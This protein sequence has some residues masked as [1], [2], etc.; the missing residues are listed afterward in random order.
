MMKRI[1]LL[2]VFTILGL[3]FI[4][5][6][7]S[8][9][10][11]GKVLNKYSLNPIP[12]AVISLVNEESSLVNAY[13][14]SNKEGFF[15]IEIPD[16]AQ[17][18]H[19]LLIIESLAYEARSIRL[20]SLNPDMVIF[21]EEKSF[22]LNEVV[23]S[24][25]PSVKQSVDTIAYDPKAYMDSTERTLEDV[26]RKIPGVEIAQNG[27]ISFGNQEIKSIL[28]DGDDLSGNDYRLISQN[29]P[30][31]MVK[32]LEFVSNYVENS[33][34]VGF[35]VP[36]SLILNVELNPEKG[37]KP[38]FN[39][40]LGLGNAQSRIASLN[41]LLFLKNLKLIQIAQH[42]SIGKS[43]ATPISNPWEGLQ[44]IVTAH[45]LL[46]GMNKV[47]SFENPEINLPSDF[48]PFR[49]NS[50]TWNVSRFHLKPS[51][52]FTSFLEIG[53]DQY[54]EQQFMEIRR[55]FSGTQNQLLF[56]EDYRLSNQNRG[57]HLQLKNRLNTGKKSNLTV[58]N[59][60][61]R[62]TENSLSQLEL[63]VD[64]Y[65]I[66]FSKPDSR[67][68]H[69][70]AWLFRLDRKN[71]FIL[72]GGYADL[73]ST[74]TLGIQTDHLRKILNEEADSLQYQN[75]S[76]KMDHWNGN[77]RWMHRLSPGINFVVAARGSSQE[78]M[79]N[80][81]RYEKFVANG[82]L[83]IKYTKPRRPTAFLELH[84]GRLALNLREANS[85][86]KN[87]IRP[88]FFT[89][90][91]IGRKQINGSWNISY[92]FHQVLPQIDQ[93]A[94]DPFLLTYRNYQQGISELRLGNKHKISA[95]FISHPNLSNFNR[96]VKM[97]KIELSKGSFDYQNEFRIDSAF[98]ISNW[99]IRENDFHRVEIWG[100]V[101]RYFAKFKTAIKIRPQLSSSIYN[102]SLDM[103][104]RTIY[105]V[106]YALQLFART[107]TSSP[108]DF[109]LGGRPSLNHFFL[110]Q[111]GNYSNAHSFSGSAYADLLIHLPFK[112][113]LVGRNEFII[114]ANQGQERQGFNFQE[115]ELEFPSLENQKLKFEFI[116]KGM[117]LANVQ[118][119][120]NNQLTD[121]YTLEQ[122]IRLRPRTFILKANLSF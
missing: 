59:R 96:S 78:E 91:F 28:L 97:L 14:F 106:N 12:N 73:I 23:I 79:F 9:S 108:F 53:L 81:T 99:I 113:E 114:L 72:D 116:L 103:E 62:N 1:L 69:H 34:L 89:Q 102:N 7:E 46:G 35:D 94:S 29:L 20:D 107:A 110:L 92:V 85:I 49:F 117:N 88:Y 26:L 58:L 43:R 13:A 77:I 119:Y 11:E 6:Q 39:L 111:S 63:G 40:E 121:I 51:Q 27:K 52:K 10:L 18:K 33:L 82:E 3:A 5:A 4:A 19:F 60:I 24:E 84:Y 109:I 50:N 25:M 93:I 83:K 100:G 67:Q 74:Q 8:I 64:T 122:R 15:I 22:Q 55:L 75:L 56:Q 95:N 115:F 54:E 66:S 41:A 38:S 37:R 31:E 105:Q 2:G 87:L 65:R 16:S 45:P 120:G 68:D 112:L 118:F 57:L 36:E 101:E 42:Q 21:L 76:L 90:F 47:P 44:G 48:I 104:A 80:Q 17:S 71:L 61:S 98:Q 86:G 30:I 32:R 70:L